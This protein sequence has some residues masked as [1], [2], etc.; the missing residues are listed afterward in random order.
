MPFRRIPALWL[1]AI[2]VSCLLI[3]VGPVAGVD[4]DEKGQVIINTAP[5]SNAEL[6]TLGSTWAVVECCGWTGTWTRRP[7]SNTFDG[8]WTGPNGMVATD[9]MTLL[10]WD[11]RT[12][13][14]VIARTNNNGRYWGIVNTANG[15][16]SN[17]GTSWYPAGAS[18]SA[19]MR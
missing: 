13:R 8:R 6:L 10:S 2:T 16:I 15:T 12:N 17:G 1:I 14:I 7:G 4:V 19:T 11:K 18:W 9:T 5:A 3:P